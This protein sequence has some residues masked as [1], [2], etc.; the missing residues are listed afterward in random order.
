M[1]VEKE[2]RQVT[3]AD[4]RLDPRFTKQL[5]NFHRFQRRLQQGGYEI[6]KKSFSIPLMERLGS[7]WL[8]K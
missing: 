7:S 3:T 2:L 5:E 6:E 4:G 1:L 8:Q